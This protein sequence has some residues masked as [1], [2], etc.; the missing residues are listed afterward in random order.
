MAGREGVLQEVVGVAVVDPGQVCQAGPT[1]A[2]GVVGLFGEGSSLKVE[3][4]PAV[5]GVGRKVTSVAGEQAGVVV[6][7]PGPE[8]LGEGVH[9]ARLPN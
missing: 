9:L 7:P 2:L 6:N 4:L 1:V 3:L 8:G 5:P